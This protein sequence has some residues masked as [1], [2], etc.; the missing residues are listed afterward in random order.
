MYNKKIL[1]RDI[2]NAPDPYVIGCGLIALIS[3]VVNS[4]FNSQIE[5]CR[6]TIVSLSRTNMTSN[7]SFLQCNIPYEEC[8]CSVISNKFNNT[9]ECI[10]NIQATFAHIWPLVAYILQIYVIYN[11]PFIKKYTHILKDIFWIIAFVIFII[12]A[13]GAVGSTCLYYKTSETVGYVGVFLYFIVVGLLVRSYI[14]DPSC[15]YHNIDQDKKLTTDN[16]NR[17]NITAAVSVVS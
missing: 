15:G 5:Y 8:Q 4:N 1:P 17:E 2:K 7:S 16:D 3:S 13:I 10:T 14:K 12:I 6:E 9:I 11:L